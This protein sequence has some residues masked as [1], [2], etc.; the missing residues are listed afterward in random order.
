MLPGLSRRIGAASNIPWRDM[1]RVSRTSDLFPGLMPIQ[2]KC[3][4]LGRI[5]PGT[6]LHCHPGRQRG[7]PCCVPW[8]APYASRHGRGI[9]HSAG[10][11]LASTVSLCFGP[12]ARRRGVSVS[13]MDPERPEQAAPFH[14]V[15]RRTGYWQGGIP[16]TS[17]RSGTDSWLCTLSLEL[18]A[19]RMA[20]PWLDNR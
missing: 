8:Y 12:H 16:R 17:R 18:S 13:T 7:Q 9:R 6:R 2:H 20:S 14:F 10:S 11:A 1:D 15:C 5:H 3:T 4:R 19:R